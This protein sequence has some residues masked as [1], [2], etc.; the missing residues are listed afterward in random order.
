MGAILHNSTLDSGLEDLLET[1]EDLIIPLLQASVALGTVKIVTNGTEN[2][3]ESSARK[4]LPNVYNFLTNGCIEVISARSLHGHELNPMEAKARV[5]K[6][7][8]RNI[9][10]SSDTDAENVTFVS[11]GDSQQERVAALNLTSILPID[12]IK[13]MVLEEGPDIFQV[14]GQIEEI[15]RLLEYSLACEGHLDFRIDAN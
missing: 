14:Q 3:V 6:D 5:F 1:L 8:T 7:E 10:H 13:I 12:R 9:M 2:W 4:F 15:H 11:I